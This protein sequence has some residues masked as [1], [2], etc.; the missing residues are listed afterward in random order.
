MVLYQ[1]EVTGL[2]HATQAWSAALDEDDNP[3]A[4]IR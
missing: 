4:F 3:D 1:A 2:T